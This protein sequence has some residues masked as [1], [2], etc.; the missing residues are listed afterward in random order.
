[1]ISER[2]YLLMHLSG[3]LVAK[4]LFTDRNFSSPSRFL[5]Y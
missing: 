5:T 2:D 3:A 4:D 1:M